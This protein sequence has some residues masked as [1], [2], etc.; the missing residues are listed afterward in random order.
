MKDTADFG[1]PALAPEDSLGDALRRLRAAF[2]AAGIEEAAL[3]ARTLLIRA[4]DTTP[5][6]L[7]A[8]PDL[9]LGRPALERLGAFA[10]RRLA[11]EPV[12]RILGEREFWGLRIRLSPE[13]LEPRPDT[14]TAVEAALRALPEGREALVLDLGTG[15][16]C[17]LLAIL[18][19]RPQARGIGVDVSGGAAM[20]ARD[21]ARLN[22]L[23]D[24]ASL[25]AGRWADALDAGFDLVVS[26]PPYIPADEIGGLSREVRVHDPRLALDGGIDGLDAYKVIVADA[27]ALLRAGAMLVLEV[28]AGQSEAV[29][30]LARAAGL[31]VEAVV[32]DLAGHARAVVARA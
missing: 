16:G 32:P 22:G 1:E 17:I 10:A 12:G 3:D 13:T 14:E 11:G 8:H 28:G 5:A 27:R 15:S 7:M 30:G 29:S 31:A 6:G 20:V 9:P 25:V 23:A 4:A 19:E 24:R 2:A 26:N 18:S 21:N